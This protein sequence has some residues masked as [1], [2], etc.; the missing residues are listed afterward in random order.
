M[1]LD[2]SN[3]A[4]LWKDQAL[5][6]LNI[7]VLSSFQKQRATIVD[8]HTAAASFMEHCSNE[9]RLRGGCPADWVWIVPPMSAS[10]TPVFHQEMVVYQLN[11]SFQYQVS[12]ITKPPKQLSL[13]SLI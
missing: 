4:S 11:P 7:A 13:F 12:T 6:E 10:L 2:T 3:T 8:H 1:G 5:V 9:Q